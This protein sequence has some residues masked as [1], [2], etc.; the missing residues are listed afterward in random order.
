MELLEACSKQVL[1]CNEEVSSYKDITDGSL[2]KNFYKKVHSERE[3]GSCHLSLMIST[4][5]APVFKSV[6][7]SIWP[8]YLCILELPLQKR[9]L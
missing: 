6:H 3:N 2:Y 1:E 5:G 4:D 9:L 7:C 8:L